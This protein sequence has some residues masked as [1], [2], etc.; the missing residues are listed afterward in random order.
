MPFPVDTQVRDQW[1]LCMKQSLEENVTDP[2]IRDKL[3]RQMADLADFM[4]NR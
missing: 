4:R 2:A 1:L 3:Y